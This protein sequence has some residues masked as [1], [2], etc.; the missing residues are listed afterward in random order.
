MEITVNNEKK[1][2]LVKFVREHPDVLMCIEGIGVCDVL[3]LITVKSVNELDYA[4]E[5]IRRQT[6][7]KKVAT[8]I[9][10]DDIQFLFENLDISGDKTNE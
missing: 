7:V 2:D 1:N 9:M 8:I 5:A 6:G 4:K 10:I 3:A